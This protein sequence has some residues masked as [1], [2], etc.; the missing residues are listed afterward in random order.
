M[1]V[2]GQ[3]CIVEPGNDYEMAHADD[4]VEEGEGEEEEEEEEEEDEE[5][6]EEEGE[7]V[8]C[9]VVA[10]GRLPNSGVPVPRC[11]PPVPTPV[12]PA[13]APSCPLLPPVFHPPPSQHLLPPQ[14][15][16]G[17][18]LDPIASLLDSAPAGGLPPSGHARFFEPPR[19]PPPQLTPLLPV[20]RSQLLSTY[21]S[22]LGEANSR[23][24]PLAPTRSQGPL[25]QLLD[26]LEE[27]GRG[28]CGEGG[29]VPAPPPPP[30]AAAV[31]HKAASSG[32]GAQPSQGAQPSFGEIIKKSI[33]ETSVIA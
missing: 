25:D 26:R 7:E 33:V 18:K 23:L 30:S 11:P 5:E 1:P 16:L 17:C 2:S 8:S 29:A 12:R 21:Y 10:P 14:A 27:P 15:P 19:S 28:P 3:F 31:A 32:A 13:S 4:V 24:E 22:R 9:G 20:D 6:E